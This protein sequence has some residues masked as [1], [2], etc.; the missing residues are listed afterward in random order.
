MPRDRNRRTWPQAVVLL[1]SLSVVAAAGLWVVFMAAKPV[2]QT[3]PKPANTNSSEPRLITFD[4]PFPIEGRYVADPYVGSKVCAECHPAESASQSRSGHAA[5]LIP[6]GR[7]EISRRLDGTTVADPELPEVRW[8]Y[9]YSAG[10]LHIER[11]APSQVQKWVADYAIGSGHHAVTYVSMINRKIP[12]I[13]EHRLTY[14]RRDKG[15]SELGMTPGHDVRPL[16]AGLTDHGGELPPRV[17]RECFRCH[18]TQLAAGDD[19][20][21]FDEETMIPNVSC[22]RCHGPGK[23]HVAAAQRH[24]PESELALPFGPERWTAETLLTM[25]GACHRR[26]SPAQAAQIRPDNPNLVRF[27]PVG[28]SQSLCYQKSSGAFSCVTCHDPH[29]RASADRPSYDRVCLSCHSRPKDGNSH[30]LVAPLPSSPAVE[31]ARVPP[32]ACP[33]SPQSRCVECHM[34]RV[35]AGQGILF[36]DHWIRIRPQVEAAPSAARPSVQP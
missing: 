21:R 1:A 3:Q 22:E 6:A 32:A 2:P 7:L 9:R 15:K 16:P 20:Q 25:C 36:S 11:Q 5:T 34:P 27:Q 17:A 31:S 12:E 18:A 23:A 28:I 14:Y 4:R 35:N 8:S 19:D 13:L 26:P 30:K 24:A 33:V 29:A 10:K